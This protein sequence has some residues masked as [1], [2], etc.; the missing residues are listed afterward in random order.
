LVALAG[1]IQLATVMQ[2]LG[3]ELNY[4]W[5]YCQ[6]LPGASSRILARQTLQEWKPWLA[7]SNGAWPSGEVEWHGDMLE[8]SARNKDE[9]RWQQQQGPAEYLIEVLTQPGQTVL[10]PFTGSGTYGLAAV[11]RDRKFVGC[12]ADAARFTQACE[13]L[14]GGAG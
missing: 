2:A 12:E 5:M 14:S 8:P 9:F 7:Y 13:A 6:P 1:K 3:S 11:A 4:G 10:D